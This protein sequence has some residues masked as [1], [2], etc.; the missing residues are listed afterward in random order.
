MPK[1]GLLGPYPLTAAEIEARIDTTI[2]AF[3]LGRMEGRRF[4][5]QHIGRTDKDAGSVLKGF[6]G[7]YEHFKYRTYVSTRRAYAKQCKLFHDFPAADT[8]GHPTP[9]PGIRVK[10]PVDSCKLAD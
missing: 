8:A 2:A 1:S 5:I 7:D 10:C 3:A 6:V 4:L 9:P